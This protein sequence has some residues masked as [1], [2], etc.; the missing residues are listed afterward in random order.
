MRL[1]EAQIAGSVGDAVVATLAAI[2]SAPARFVA[3][4]HCGLGLVSVEKAMWGK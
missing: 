1:P 3:V 4:G 2:G